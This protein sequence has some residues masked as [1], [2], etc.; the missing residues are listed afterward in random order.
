M[1]TVG[2]GVSWESTAAVLH[3]TV[4]EVGSRWEAA[5]HRR[6]PSSV[7]CDYLDSRMGAGV[8]G[9]LKRAGVYVYL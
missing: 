4:W 1:G 5:T 6:E 3:T 2:A 8:G 9:K 7:L